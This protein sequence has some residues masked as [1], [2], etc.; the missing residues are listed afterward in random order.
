MKAGVTIDD[1]NGRAENE[2]GA[3]FATTKIE[4]AVG[5]LRDFA[6]AVKD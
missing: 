1:K 4:A 2:V 3:R 6:R 5:D